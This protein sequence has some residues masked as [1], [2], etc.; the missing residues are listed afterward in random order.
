MAGPSPCGGV[1]SATGAWRKPG[2][3]CGNGVAA[4]QHGTHGRE[5]GHKRDVIGAPMVETAAIMPPTGRAERDRRLDHS[6]K[7]VERP[8][9]VRTGGAE[10]ADGA[11]LE[12]RGDME[13]PRV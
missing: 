8:G 2:S 10:D 6:G 5:H 1:V 11:G 12:R 9:E 7:R 4:R 13:E 3:G